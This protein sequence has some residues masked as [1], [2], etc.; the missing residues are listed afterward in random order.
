MA[1]DGVVFVGFGRL[2]EE[3]TGEVSGFGESG[4]PEG[5][6]VR[7]GGKRAGAGAGSDCRDRG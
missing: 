5:F 6:V 7:D 3:A 1:E 4:L 2:W